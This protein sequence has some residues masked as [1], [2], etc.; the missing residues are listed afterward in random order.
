VRSV[1]HPPV[2][3]IELATVL[4]ALGDPIRLGIVKVLSDGLEHV[5]ADFDVN[6]GQSTLSH[7]MKTLR[8]AGVVR[9]RPEGTRCFVS[10]RLELDEQLPGLLEAVLSAARSERRESRASL[11]RASWTHDGI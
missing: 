6:V 5:Q 9:S 1:E 10:L 7:H 4:S 8:S 3:A 11:D 2:E